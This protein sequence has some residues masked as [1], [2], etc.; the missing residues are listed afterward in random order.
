METRKLI[1]HWIKNQQDIGFDF[2]HCYFPKEQMYAE[3]NITNCKEEFDAAWIE[4]FGARKIAPQLKWK[5][6]KVVK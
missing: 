6:G 5:N 1:V 3:L 2:S 4:C